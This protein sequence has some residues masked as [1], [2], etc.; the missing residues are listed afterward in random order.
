MLLDDHHLEFFQKAVYQ[1][2]PTNGKGCVGLCYPLRCD[3]E[4]TYCIGVCFCDFLLHVMLAPY[5][6]SRGWTNWHDMQV[7]EVTVVRGSSW[8]EFTL[9]KGHFYAGGSLYLLSADGTIWFTNNDQG[10]S[11]HRPLRS[12]SQK[13][14]IHSMSCVLGLVVWMT[15]MKTHDVS[16]RID[17]LWLYVEAYIAATAKPFIFIEQ[18]DGHYTIPAQHSEVFT[19][20]VM[21][22]N[23]I[24]GM[25]CITCFLLRRKVLRWLAVQCMFDHDRYSCTRVNVCT[26]PGEAPHPLHS[27]SNYWRTVNLFTALIEDAS[28]DEGLTRN[29]EHWMLRNVVTTEIKDDWSWLHCMPLPQ[30]HIL[31]GSSSWALSLVT[32]NRHWSWV[33]QGYE[34]QVA[35]QGT[36]LRIYLLLHWLSGCKSYSGRVAAP[37][38]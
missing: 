24:T 31:R 34:Q 25:A 14:R 17:I 3:V 18:A 7:E 30:R 33:S 9:Y 11:K 13:L 5:L 22:H 37:S 16:M 29:V 10:N 21:G 26:I 23:E 12:H 8:A 4:S 1:T 28:V 27:R 6:C 19:E 38:V 32:L 15:S 2:S 35:N 36:N 20:R